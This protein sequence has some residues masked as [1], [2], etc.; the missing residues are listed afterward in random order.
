[1]EK[2]CDICSNLVLHNLKTFYPHVIQHMKIVVQRVKRASVTV[3]GAVTGKIDH[4]LL[5][6]A[7]I[8]KK[9]TEEEMDWCCEKIL[10]LRIFEDTDGKMNRSVC[11]VQGGILVVSQFTLYGDTRKGTRP[12]FIEAARPEVAEPLY[13]KM[14]GK[15]KRDSELKVES[16]I[17]GAMMDVELVNDGPV[18][19]IIEKE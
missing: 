14:I 8:H 7:G 12:G 4:G 15:F 2:D 3:D 6:L 10:K 13:E 1:M 16:G 19:L 11:D 9:D 18:T 17:F 5:L